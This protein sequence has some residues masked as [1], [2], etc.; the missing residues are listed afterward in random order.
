M[1]GPA[2]FVKDR[3]YPIPPEIENCTLSLYDSK[4]EDIPLNP[5]PCDERNATEKDIFPQCRCTV[6]QEKSLNDEILAQVSFFY[7][8]SWNYNLN[9]RMTNFHLLLLF[10]LLVVLSDRSQLDFW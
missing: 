4:T 8:F 6:E 7:H 10:S 9:F 3:L 5:Q 1:N 2:E